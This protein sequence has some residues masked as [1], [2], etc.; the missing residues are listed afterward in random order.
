MPDLMKKLLMWVIAFCIPLGLG[1]YLGYR[2]QQSKIDAL[3]QK[4]S[5]YKE[6]GKTI[7]ALKGDVEKQFS[8]NN[9]SIVSAYEQELKGILGRFSSAAEIVNGESAT[10]RKRA[11]AAEGERKKI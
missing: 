8:D 9:K 5:D 3:E 1:I 7:Q 2:H 10:L 4:L 6:L 11:T